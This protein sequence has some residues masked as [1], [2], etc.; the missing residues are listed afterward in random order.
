MSKMLAF[1]VKWTE[2][3]H[4]LHEGDRDTLIKKSH[5]I[6]Y[7]GRATRDWNTLIEQSLNCEIS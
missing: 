6:K 4:I 1:F 5:R 3:L 2:T 7:R